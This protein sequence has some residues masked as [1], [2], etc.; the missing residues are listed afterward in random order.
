MRHMLSSWKILSR[1]GTLI[2]K[3]K[4]RIL[5]IWDTSPVTFRI[6]L[7]LVHLRNLWGSG[8]KPF[9]F[10]LVSDGRSYTSEQQFSPIFRYSR[11]LRKQIGVVIEHKSIDNALKNN[12]Q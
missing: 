11:L 7:T 5:K 3:L 10:L 6:R 8:P 9:R 12:K 4:G 1:L 2:A